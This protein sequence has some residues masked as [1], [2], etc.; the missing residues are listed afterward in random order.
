MPP[1]EKESQQQD[2]NQSVDIPIQYTEEDLNA[3]RKVRSTLRKEYSFTDDQIGSKFLALCCIVS[4]NRVDD[5]VKK[6][7]TLFR[8]FSVCGVDGVY[9]EALFDDE[10][11]EKF[12]VDHYAPCGKDSNGRAILWIHPTQPTTP[13]LEKTSIRS[14]IAY[15]IAIHADEK[16]LREGVTL[17]VHT[18]DHQLKNNFGN[19][20]KLQKIHQSYPIRPQAI[21]I[22][23]TSLAMRIVING[24]I[25]VASIFTKAKILQRIKFVSTAQAVEAVPIESAPKYLDGSGG[26]IENLGEWT[27]KRFDEFPIP[28]L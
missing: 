28:N 25:Q 16:S 11:L 26:G 13:D 23:G 1:Q 9:E 20:A 7:L 4:K 14:G 18:R 10:G 21:M 12:L 6:Y 22:V 8:A 24:L 17:V 3:M 27:K 19:E 5:C 15:S 2:V